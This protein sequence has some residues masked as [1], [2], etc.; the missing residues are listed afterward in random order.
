CS[1]SLS[2]GTESAETVGS[3]LTAP[4]RTADS[5]TSTHKNCGLGDIRTSRRFDKLS[6]QGRG[7]AETVP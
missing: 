6:E 4:T 1:L 3:R 7:P 5:R 2:K